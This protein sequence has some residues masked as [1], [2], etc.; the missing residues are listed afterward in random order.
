MKQRIPYLKGL[1][2]SIRDNAVLLLVL[3]VLSATCLVIGISNAMTV[4]LIFSLVAVS[5]LQVFLLRKYY[6][7]YLVQVFL[8][9]LIIVEVFAA[10]RLDRISPVSYFHDKEYR[11][12]IEGM[13]SMPLPNIQKAREVKLF[14]KKTVYDVLYSTDSFRRRIPEDTGCWTRNRSRH[15]ILLGCS[16]TFG[17]GLDYKNTL[18]SLIEETDTAFS[19]YNYG[20]SGLAPHQMALMFEPGMNIINRRTIPQRQGFMLYTFIGD[21]LERVYGGSSYLS[22]GYESPD[23]SIVNGRLESKKRSR[24]RVMM[25][26]FIE[27]SKTL[28][29]F[30][31]GF[32]Y[33]HT[34][35]YYRRFAGIVNYCAERYQTLFP[36]NRF[37]VGLFPEN[38]GS[39]HE[40]MY[41][42]GW[43]PF[44]DSNVHLIRVPVPPDFEKMSPKYWI[45]NDGH[46]NRTMNS[47]YL[48]FV[49]DQVRRHESPQTPH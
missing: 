18:S 38:W 2:V 33:P 6:G 19:A 10:R 43:V 36:G 16:F 13:G 11:T 28:S 8:I 5:T 26:K 35:D 42:L 12:V 24:V 46:P 25:S 1:Q 9:F 4:E 3:L 48:R 31:V 27:H 39:D 14:E 17:Y 34:D 45:P 22:W 30:R 21:H 37:Y 49:M 15:A 40:K 20:F 41:D 47:H 23:V 29:L 44:L 32:R 7:I